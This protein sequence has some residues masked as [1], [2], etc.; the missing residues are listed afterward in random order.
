MNEPTTLLG[1]LRR[2]ADE[3]P[4]AAAL[5]DGRG[6]VSYGAYARAVGAVAAALTARGLPPGARVAVA[7]P[8]STDLA[9]AY[10]GAAAAGCWAFPINPSAGDGADDAAAWLTPSAVLVPTVAEGTRA[11]RPAAGV[12]VIGVAE[13]ISAGESLPPERWQ[14][15]GPDGV[16]YLN[17]TSGSGGRVK[18]AA[19]T[20]GNLV[21]NAQAAG[22]ALDLGA[23]DVHLVTFAA[24]AHPHEC[25]TRAL[26]AGGVAVFVESILPR[27]ILGTVER[28]GVTAL[29]GVPPLF[30]SLLPLATAFRVPTLRVA[31][32]GGMQT[33]AWLGAGFRAAFGV[34]LRRVWGSTET[35]GIA[36]LAGDD[37]PEG[38]L[39]KPLYGYT[40]RAA[41]ANGVELGA[42][43]EGELAVAGPACIRA[44]WRG[45]RLEPVDGSYVRTGDVVRRDAD[46]RF[47]FVDR[48]EGLMK[49]AG[50]KVY[51]AEVERM[52]GEHPGV[53]EVAVV[54]APDEARGQAPVAYVVPRPHL[55]LTANDVAAFARQKLPPIKRPRVVHVVASLPTLAS[56]KV[57]KRRLGQTATAEQEALAAD[58]EE[59]LKLLNR[60]LRRLRGLGDA[61]TRDM[62][63][64]HI[65]RLLAANAGP[66]HDETVEEIF[67]KLNE[68]MGY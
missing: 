31:E 55:P 49:V 62:M 5:R 15:A 30:R 37:E 27:T 61:V 58:D 47:F 9:V 17:V 35:S 48:L 25:F 66:L 57:D 52:L 6:D 34:P 56:G 16:F 33:P 8:K 65:K 10:L 50:E 32:A 63:N 45:G 39:G 26:L 44:Y 43:E 53:A 12:P 22:A 36:F 38:S 29:M 51:A 68:L 20:N 21:A 4:D 64:R 42:G 3:R 54:A 41:D 1:A 67:A 19:A 59:L 14:D 46:G 13:S 60:R 40:A 18:A 23:D 7:V 2:W 24:Y 11:V 28:F